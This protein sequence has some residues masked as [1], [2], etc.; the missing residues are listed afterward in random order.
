M[1]VNHK[2]TYRPYPAAKQ[3]AALLH[4]KQA[5][6]RLYTAALAPRRTAWKQGKPCVMAISA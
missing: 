6:P 2:R 1:M 5:H 3:V 4:A